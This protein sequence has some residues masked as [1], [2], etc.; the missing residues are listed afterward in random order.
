MC[1]SLPAKK[2]YTRPSRRPPFA[3]PKPHGPAVLPAAA[4]RQL[5][6][7][8]RRARVQSLWPGKGREGLPCKRLLSLCYSL[9]GRASVRFSPDP[10]FWWA[11]RISLHTLDFLGGGWNKL[12]PELHPL[13]AEALREIN[14]KA[15]LWRCGHAM[16]SCHLPLARSGRRPKEQPLAEYLEGSR[17][18]AH[19]FSR[20]LVI[21][22]TWPDEPPPKRKA[23]LEGY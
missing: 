16:E 23:Y 14:A 1:E 8:A 9:R 13:A 19:F 11:Q 12:Q 17:Q 2:P 5:T 6:Q 22:E 10:L 20:V 4:R 15:A 7:L 3:V 18:A 21:G